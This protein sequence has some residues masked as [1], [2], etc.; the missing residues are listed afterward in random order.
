MQ[1]ADV[2]QVGAWS[3]R[4]DVD[5][6]VSPGRQQTVDAERC[7]NTA[8]LTLPTHGAPLL[9]VVAFDVRPRAG[10]RRVVMS[11]GGEHSELGTHENSTSSATSCGTSARVETGT[12]DRRARFVVVDC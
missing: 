5:A 4:V 1:L 2:Q 6:A 12:G 9:R 11:T 10:Q 8:E 3:E 7:R